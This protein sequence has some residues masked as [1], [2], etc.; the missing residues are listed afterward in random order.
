MA[1]QSKIHTYRFG[2]MPGR[3]AEQAKERLGGSLAG[4]GMSEN[5]D[6]NFNGAMRDYVCHKYVILLRV[7]DLFILT[8]E[9]RDGFKIDGGMWDK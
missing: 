3:N 6:G 4:C 9:M 1:N 8:D 2:G 5:R 7:R